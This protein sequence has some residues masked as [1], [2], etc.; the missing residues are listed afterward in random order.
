[1]V[2]RAENGDVLG[3]LEINRDITDRQRMMDELA[4][5]D[6][7]KNEFLATLAHELRNP[8]APM[9]NGIRV[10]NA[11]SSQEPRAVEA[12]DAIKRSIDH[13][14]RLI[15][16]LLDISRITRGHIELRREQ[17]EIGAAVKE[18][19]AG[20]QALSGAANR[21]L[22]VRVP[23]EPLYVDADEVRL[24]QIVENLLHNAVKFSDE[25]GSIEIVL[26]RKAGRAVLEVRDS[27][28]GIAPDNL[29]RI[30]DPFVQADTSIERIR[31]GLG[32]GLALVK[33]LVELHGGTVAARSEGVGKG[34]VFAV[35]LP[36]STSTPVAAKVK[37]EPAPPRKAAAPAPLSGRRFLIVDD[38]VDAANSLAALLKVMDNEARVANDGP[39]A[40]RVAREYQPDIVL[41]DIGLPGMNGYDVARALRSDSS[42][43][44]PLIVAVSGYGSREA[45]ER[46][47][48]AGFDAHFVKPMEIG[49]L[50]QFL[51]SS[52]VSNSRWPWRWR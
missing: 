41:L 31:G 37:Q 4:A 16:D 6:R 2:H 36:L 39:G 47:V 46:S 13:M 15:D 5:A 23:N 14:T 43:G 30:W 35:E 19:V 25:G 21:E 3:I 48:E 11:I 45:M 12:R 51:A 28:I 44:K 34:S 10:L 38:N 20:F 27:G 1:V 50:E 29:S 49:E 42:N 26:E 22:S 24:T 8:L 9:S 17:V 7:R 32:I 40:L 33:S 18:V 52:K